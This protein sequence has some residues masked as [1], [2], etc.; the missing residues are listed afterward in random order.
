MKLL[1]TKENLA[2]IFIFNTVVDWDYMSENYQFEVYN[3]LSDA[4][5]TFIR[6]E[7][8]KNA[9][10]GLLEL[11]PEYDNLYELIITNL[12]QATTK[13]IFIETMLEEQQMVLEALD[14]EERMDY[15]RSHNN[16]DCY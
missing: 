3:A 8:Q 6:T 4:F 5:E 11:H 10:F 2:Q 13:E 14:H 15:L 16:C 7:C 9:K 1:L 12:L